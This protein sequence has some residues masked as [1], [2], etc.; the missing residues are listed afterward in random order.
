MEEKLTLK[1]IYVRALAEDLTAKEAAW[2]YKCNYRSLLTRGS[3]HHL[4][5]LRSHWRWNDQ[6]MLNEIPKKDLR[7]LKRKCED[8]LELINNSLNK[9]EQTTEKPAECLD[10]SHSN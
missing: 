4:P 3:E 7:I 5:A 6:R 2:K 10:Q 1:E 9:H 8:W